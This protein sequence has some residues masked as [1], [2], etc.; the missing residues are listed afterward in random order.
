M[1]AVWR[2]KH[3]QGCCGAWVFGVLPQAEPLIA[4][5]HQ[6]ELP[7]ALGSPLFS[8]SHPGELIPPLPPCTFLRRPSQTPG[9]TLPCISPAAESH[10]AASLWAICPHS[11]CHLPCPLWCH[12]PRV[13]TL[14]AH[15]S[16]DSTPEGCPYW[17]KARRS[18][19]LPFLGP[20]P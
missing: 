13:Y 17:T 16:S 5:V 11:P 2:W 1:A 8:L 12:L 10:S 20:S 19:G 7:P 6:P 15:G 18:S 4:H 14:Q 9:Q 3:Q